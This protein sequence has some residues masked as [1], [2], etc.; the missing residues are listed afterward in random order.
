MKVTILMPLILLVSINTNQLCSPIQSIQLHQFRDF[1]LYLYQ[2]TGYLPENI[3]SCSKKAGNDVYFD[4]Q[5]TDTLAPKISIGH[6]LAVEGQL[7]SLAANS[8]VITINDVR[9]VDNP[10]GSGWRGYFSDV[11]ADNIL[12]S[13]LT[14]EGRKKNIVIL[15]YVH[16]IGDLKIIHI[17]SFF[18]EGEKKRRFF[19]VDTRKTSMSYIIT[20]SLE[21][22]K[23]LG[24]NSF[25][26]ATFS[27]VNLR[28]NRAGLSFGFDKC[29]VSLR[30]YPDQA[31]ANLA[32]CSTIY[33]DL[34]SGLW[35]IQEDKIENDDQFL[36]MFLFLNMQSEKE[37][38]LFSLDGF[39]FFLLSR[40]RWMEPL[41]FNGN[42]I[43]RRIK[44]LTCKL[45]NPQSYIGIR[46]LSV[47]DET[48][49]KKM[50]AG[51]EKNC[52]NR[53]KK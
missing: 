48:L 21:F 23:K 10:Y 46:K 29:L 28:S 39:N 2:N 20:D 42:Q 44:W 34:Q 38:N 25:T 3:N 41:V 14:Q 40:F 51:I 8:L 26:K 36:K 7:Y 12:R 6:S 5:R 18:F 33:N 37:P 15:N 13:L 4:N 47:K 9:L 1:F 45:L 16:G 52:Q 17:I 30:V 53:K 43:M 27:P 35:K 11:D 19:I 32:S 24:I 22:V 31:V 49:I 50:F